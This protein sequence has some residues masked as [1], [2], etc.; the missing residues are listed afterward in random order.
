MLDERIAL[1][2]SLDNQDKGNL[3]VGGYDSL[4]MITQKKIGAVISAVWSGMFKPDENLKYLLI[5]ADDRPTYDMSKHFE[6]AV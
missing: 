6:K 1:V 4:N 2:M 5:E 3:Y